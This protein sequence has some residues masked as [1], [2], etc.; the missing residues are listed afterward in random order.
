MGLRNYLSQSKEENTDYK[1]NAI[2][3]E[4]I[5]TPVSETSFYPH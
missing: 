2:R 3:W 4:I 1:S 5:F